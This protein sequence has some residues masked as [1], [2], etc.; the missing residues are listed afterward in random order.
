MIAGVN[1]ADV[2]Y[3]LYQ[4]MTE[5][6]LRAEGQDMLGMTEQEIEDAISE[7]RANMDDIFGKEQSL[8][9]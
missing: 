8:C 6:E 5:S 2:V 9:K 7:F 3:A 4:G 1:M